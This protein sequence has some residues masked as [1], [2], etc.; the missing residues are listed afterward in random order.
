MNPDAA[1]KRTQTKM[2][3]M[4]QIYPSEL[5]LSFTFLSD[6]T[7]SVR[8][9]PATA[10]YGG[11]IVGAFKITPSPAH[12]VCHF[13]VPRSFSCPPGWCWCRPC[14][15]ESSSHSKNFTGL[16]QHLPGGLWNHLSWLQL[17]AWVLQRLPCLH[18][19]FA[20][21]QF[22]DPFLVLQDDTDVGLIAR[23]LPATAKTSQGLCK[24]FTGASDITF[25]DFSSKTMISFLSTNDDS[26]NS[27]EAKG[28]S[29]IPK[30]W[31][32]L[33]WGH[34]LVLLS[35]VDLS[36]HSLTFYHVFFISQ[37][38]Q[39]ILSKKRFF[40]F[41]CYAKCLQLLEWK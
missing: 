31:K 30:T 41:F 9:L 3:T 23:S 37:K 35:H 19:R 32:N 5:I 36:F 40:L 20:I 2:S 25:L 11:I 16:A 7:L 15:P 34:Y 1:P 22:Q 26:N 18:I 12:Q 28:L 24:I 10:R 33:C 39:L 6:L 4:T 13:T 27:L 17:Q 29:V 8:C 21:S 14:S 38:D